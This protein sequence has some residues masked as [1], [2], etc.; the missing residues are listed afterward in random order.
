VRAVVVVVVDAATFVDAVIP[1]PA[2]ATAAAGSSLEVATVAVVVAFSASSAAA[3]TT[4]AV[5][6]VVIHPYVATAPAVRTVVIHPCVA[7]AAAAATATAAVPAVFAA[8]PAGELIIVCK[9][10]FRIMTRVCYVAFK[11]V[12]TTFQRLFTVMVVSV[13]STRFVVVSSLL[14]RHVLAVGVIS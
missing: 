2:A 5:L 12:A 13:A 9:L 1:F 11:P 14:P 3:V 6:T 4:P 7:T 8:A 10:V